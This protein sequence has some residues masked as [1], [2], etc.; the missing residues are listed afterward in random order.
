[1]ENETL[2][3]K[4]SLEEQDE[5]LE[6][7]ELKEKEEV[8]L[9]KYMKEKKQ[10]QEAERKLA[11]YEAA[12][13][14]T[15]QENKYVQN[16][17]DPQVAKH[18]AEQDAKFAKLEET[19][20]LGEIKELSKKDLYSDAGDHTDD[21]K[22]AM[23]TYGVP[24]DQAYMMTVWNDLKAKEFSEKQAQLALYKENAEEKEI[25]TGPSGIEKQKTYS[26]WDKNDDLA[27]RE[28]QKA[29]PDAKWTKESYYKTIHSE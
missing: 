21:I 28:L 25:E 16:G 19:R 24:A 12:Q 14:R 3:E 29:M 4:D 18:F 7:V 5:Q 13:E 1:M 11:E 20:I 6:D 23:Q 15:E 26:L 2:E 22:K 10:R 9:S 17:V 8:P 27:L